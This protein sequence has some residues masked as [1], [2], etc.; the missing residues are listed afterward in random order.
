MIFGRPFLVTI[1]ATIKIR[2]GIMTLVFKSM[3]LNVKIFSNSR[4]EDFDEEEEASCI[5]VVTESSLNLICKKDPIESVLT[6]SVID[7]GCYTPKE[8]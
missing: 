7:G 8:E 5:E 3:T 6:R 2:S 1:D 4:P